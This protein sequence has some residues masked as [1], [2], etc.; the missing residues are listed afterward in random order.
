MQRPCDHVTLKF[1]NM[2]IWSW[3]SWSHLQTTVLYTV[4]E[5]HSPLESVFK[6]SVE[7]IQYR[8]VYT[9]QATLHSEFHSIQYRTHSQY[10]ALYTVE[11]TLQNTGHFTEYTWYSTGHLTQNWPLYTVQATIHSRS[12]FTKYRP[13][14]RVY[15]IQYRP[16]DSW[17]T[18]GHYSYTQYRPLYTV[19]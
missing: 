17:H 2:T 5:E 13:L 14:Y 6:F 3:S 10:R 9:A 4:S 15:L 7:L 8:T 16:F 19:Q 12:H 18:I 1:W 11:V